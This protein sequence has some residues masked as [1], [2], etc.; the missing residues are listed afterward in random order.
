MVQATPA[1]DSDSDAPPTKKVR[2]EKATAPVDSASDSDSDIPK[3]KTAKPKKALRETDS[4]NKSKRKSPEKSSK[5]NS[6]GEEAGQ[7]EK[8]KK[9]KL[10]GAVLP[11]F[12]WDPIM[13]VRRAL[14][15]HTS[16]G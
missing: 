14:T 12:Q 3:T 13:N 2:K 1:S 9:R 8:K 4:G 5:A 10:L 7:P 15:Y 6:P 16:A 11:A